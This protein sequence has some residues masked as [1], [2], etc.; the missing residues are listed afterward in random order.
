MAGGRPSANSAASEPASGPMVSPEAP[1]P[2]ATTRPSSPGTG[3][4]SGRMPEPIGRK[5]VTTR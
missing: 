2:V 4:S 1:K 5:P 3:P